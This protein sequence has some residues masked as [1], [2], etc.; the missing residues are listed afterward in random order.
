MQQEEHILKSW[1]TNAIPWITAIDKQEIESRR[2]VTNQAIVNAIALYRP[3]SLL[4]LGCGEGWLCRAAAE[5][6]PSLQKFFGVDAV[7][8]LIEKAK[9]FSVG[10]YFVASYQHIIEGKYSTPEK[11][12]MI[13]INF[14]LFGNELVHRLLTV[15]KAFLNQNGHLLIQTLHPL[16]ATGD[17]A[18][19]DGWRA[20][21][22]AGF[23]SSFSDPAPWYF[24]TLESWIALFI[25]VGYSVD[26]L[27]EPL[28]PVT[29]KPA[30]V[31]FVLRKV[32]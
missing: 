20:G 25:S 28:H 5:Q 15:I 16:L 8:A 4:D 31:I 22:W 18:Y 30:S 26:S 24:R 11:V 6:I 23:A 27:K 13:T 21:S 1:H 12:D 3:A 9:K 14:A 19:E 32:F 2:L 7:E 17:A 10:E 29:K